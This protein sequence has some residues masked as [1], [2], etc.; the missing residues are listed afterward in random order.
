MAN[1]F[2]VIEGTDCSGKETQSRLLVER[3]NN[4][5]MKS[6]YLTFPDYDTPTGKIVA[7]YLNKPEYS[8]G[9][10]IKTERLFME[11]ADKVDPLVASCYYA[12]DRRYNMNKIIDLLDQGYNVILDRYVYSNMAHQGGKIKSKTA[13]TKIIDTL[14]QL[15]FGILE[16]PRPDAVIFLHMPYEQACILKKKRTNLDDHEKNVEHL[17]NA[18]QTYLELCEKFSFRYINCTKNNQIRS[19]EDISDEILSNVEEIELKNYRK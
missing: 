13:R 10:P 14:D 11:G 19:I 18:E 16:L 8:E 15:E 5:G 6:A 2:I 3:L 12:A 9:L 7:W 1:K 4:L 17:K